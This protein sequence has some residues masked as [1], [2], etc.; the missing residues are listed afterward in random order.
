MANTIVTPFTVD[1]GS[2]WN[3]NLTI[4]VDGSPL[5]L[6][7]FNTLIATW[8][9]DEANPVNEMIITGPRD[10]DANGIIKIRTSAKQTADMKSNGVFVVFG[11]SQILIRGY[12]SWKAV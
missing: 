9:V 11:D 1:A 3:T 4:K 10:E 12:T 6:S 8:R 5:D 2:E 7:V